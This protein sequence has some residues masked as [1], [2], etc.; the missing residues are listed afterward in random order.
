MNAP[1]LDIKHVMARLTIKKT[2]VYSL[3]ARGDLPQPLK[4]GGSSRWVPEEIDAALE[5]MAQR[6]DEPRTP[7][8][9]GRPRK[10]VA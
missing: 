2:A 10:V 7:T 4:I 6:R 1:L 5:K 8:K 9:R 3:V